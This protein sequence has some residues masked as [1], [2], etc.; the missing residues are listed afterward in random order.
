MSTTATNTKTVL[1]IEDSAY[2]AESLADMLNMSGYEPI[3]AANGRDGL[4]MA[5]EKEPDLTLLDIRLPDI[6]GY[7]VYKGIRETKWGKKAKII[8]LTASESIENISKNIDLDREFVLFK[9]EWSMPDLL[10]K[11]KEVIES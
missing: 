6:D 7:E 10:K 8:V 2:L 1:V 4:E 3:L 11:M 5:I 9:P